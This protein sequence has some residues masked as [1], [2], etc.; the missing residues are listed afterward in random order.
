MAVRCDEPAAAEEAAQAIP[1]ANQTPDAL[2]CVARYRQRGLPAA[3]SSLF[4]LAWLEPQRLASTL[5]ELGDA[6]LDRDWQTFERACEW[7]SVDEAQLP[8]WFPAWYL[9]EH[10][11]V[12]KE[13]NGVEFP[14][15]P[16][17]N[18]AR[19]LLHIL[20]LERHGDWRRLRLQ[21]MQLRGLNP[22]LFSLYMARREVQFL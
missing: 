16:P 11:A 21:R 4:T 5:V 8:A 13:L 1:R 7:E 14:D 9:L 10:P 20:E 12:G 2:H 3:R 22:E 19:L 6:L 17:A 18:A 15:S